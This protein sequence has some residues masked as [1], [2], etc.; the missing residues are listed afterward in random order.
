MVPMHVMSAYSPGLQAACI[1]KRKAPATLGQTQAAAR[2][3]Q[4]DELRQEVLGQR[5]ERRHGKQELQR[6]VHLRTTLRP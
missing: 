1:C 2:L 6:P 4:R 3:G 5:G